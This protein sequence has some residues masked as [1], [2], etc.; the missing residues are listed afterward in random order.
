MIGSAG[1][2]VIRGGDGNDALAGKGGNDL[3]YG[4]SG[5]DTFRFDAAGWG[6][7]TVADHRDNYDKLDLRGSGAGDFAALTVAQVGVDTVVSFGA[8]EIVLQGINANSINQ[9]DFIFA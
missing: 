5:R 1:A 3:L 8:D 6:H 4:G 7:D 2:E 9:S